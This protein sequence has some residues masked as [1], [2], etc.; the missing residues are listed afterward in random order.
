MAA[1]A[2]MRKRSLQSAKIFRKYGYLCDTHTAVGVKVYED[3]VQQTGDPMKTIIASTASPYK[4]TGSVLKAICSDPVPEDDFAQV[5]LLEKLSGLPAPASLLALKE[6]EVRF[7]RS[8]PEGADGGGS[9]SNAEINKTQEEFFLRAWSRYSCPPVPTGFCP[10]QKAV[11]FAERNF[12]KS[13]RNSSWQN[14]GQF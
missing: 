8:V 4:F 7:K 3:Y 6:K 10:V 5:E 11:I 1:T 9:P 13:Y 2:P 12:D 14:A